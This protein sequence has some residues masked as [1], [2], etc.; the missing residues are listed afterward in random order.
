MD[1]ETSASLFNVTLSKYD[2]S[3]MEQNITTAQTVY[4]SSIVC[5]GIF[6]NCVVLIVVSLSRQLHYP[7]HIF[8]AAVSIC[9]CVLLFDCGIEL[10]AVHNRDYLACLFVVLL[11]PSDYS[12]LLICLALAAFDRYISIVRYEW[13]KDN[14]TNRG[15]IILISIVVS[16]A[17]VIFTSPFWT[18][19]KSIYNY[20]CNFVVI[21]WASTWN[22]FLSIVCVILH[23]MIFIETKSFIR[24]YVPKYRREP[25]AVKFVANSSIRQ[26]SCAGNF[27]IELKSIKVKI[28]DFS[29]I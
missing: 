10:V 1:A 26:S 7:R 4:R 18:G 12:V 28:L 27:K 2:I 15:V 14:V 24:Q 22:L 5:I 19:Y 20:S 16:V 11:Y 3:I 29:F 23:C 8:W 21:F 17:I 6:L 9:E 13:Y 25:V